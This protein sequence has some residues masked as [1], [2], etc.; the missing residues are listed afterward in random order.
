MRRRKQKKEF[1]FYLEK[2]VK[3]KE[4]KK[5]YTYMDSMA[6]PMGY[7]GMPAADYDWGKDGIVMRKL[8]F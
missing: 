1:F 4:M 5:V 7:A 6:N 8:K 3:Q 2:R